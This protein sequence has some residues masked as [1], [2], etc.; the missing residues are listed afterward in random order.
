MRVKRRCWQ[1]RFPAV[2]LSSD[3]LVHNVCIVFV[4]EFI[5]QS[6]AAL[7]IKNVDELLKK[8][9]LLQM[10]SLACLTNIYVFGILLFLLVG[11]Y[12]YID[13]LG[14]NI[15]FPKGML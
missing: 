2:L 8:I 11:L 6:Y 15:C 3:N 12:L 4:F 10:L 7:C 13:D 1:L 14:W 9:P 5:I